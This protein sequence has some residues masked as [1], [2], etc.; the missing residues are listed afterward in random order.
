MPRINK[1][2]TNITLTNI[3]MRRMYSKFFKEILSF[4]E[5]HKN[6]NIVI[7]ECFDSNIE[8]IINHCKSANRI[9]CLEL[10]EQDNFL[11]LQLLLANIYSLSSYPQ[12]SDWE[13]FLIRDNETKIREISDGIINIWRDIQNIIIDSEFSEL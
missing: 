3:K 7:M 12:D 9:L 2:T 8:G 6:E 10:D 1:I 13:K 4:D 11:H 5:F